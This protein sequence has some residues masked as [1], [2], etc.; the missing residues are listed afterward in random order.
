MEGL[1]AEMFAGFPEKEREQYPKSY[2]HVVHEMPVQDGNMVQTGDIFDQFKSGESVK[3]ELTL[4]IGPA[5]KICELLDLAYGESC[6]NDG[7]NDIMR[8]IAH[9]HP[10]LV[11]EYSYLPWPTDKKARLRNETW[12]V[13]SND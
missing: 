8:A 1:N 10:E 2:F 12:K 11:T 13:W 3:W 9:Q 6:L 7:F 4:S 5:R